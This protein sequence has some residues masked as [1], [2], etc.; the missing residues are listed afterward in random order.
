LLDLK[1][2]GVAVGQRFNVEDRYR[3]GAGHPRQRRHLRNDG[4]WPSSSA[5]PT[6]LRLE[7]IR[8]NLRLCG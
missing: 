7:A 8:R 2:V 1:A 4:E 6:I 5:A 3:T